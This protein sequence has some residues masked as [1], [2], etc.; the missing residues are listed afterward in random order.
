MGDTK[1]GII[2]SNDGK[3]YGA[4]IGET[5]RE[6]PAGVAHVTAA[7]WS[8]DGALL[9][10]GS[11]SAAMHIQRFAKGQGTTVEVSSQVCSC[12]LICLERSL[13]MSG[14]V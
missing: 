8:S 7:A 10:L 4:V 3:L 1:E 14:S 13:R 11:N 5:L 12:L 9:G 2:V 6:R